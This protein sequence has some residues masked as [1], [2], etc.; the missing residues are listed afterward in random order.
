MNKLNFFLALA[1]IGCALAVVTS[2]HRARK[3]IFALEQEREHSRELEVEWGQLQLEQSTWATPLRVERIA[4]SKLEMS[5][6][7]SK[8]VV[9]MA[10]P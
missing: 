4:H 7:D 2:E 10:K 9:L 5:V 8:R 6:P 1:A 3:L